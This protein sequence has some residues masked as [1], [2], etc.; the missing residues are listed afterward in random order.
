LPLNDKQRSI[1][2]AMLGV[3]GDLRDMCGTK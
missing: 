1:L 2:Q 3:L